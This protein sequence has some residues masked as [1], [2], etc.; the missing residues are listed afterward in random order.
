[1]DGSVDEQRP[2]A[3]DDAAD[4]LRVDLARR[5][6]PPAGRALDLAHDLVSLVVAE[7]YRGRQ[8]DLDPTLFAGNK[9]FELTLDFLDLGR[10]TAFRQDAKQVADELV[11]FCEERLEDR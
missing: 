9:A 6:H 8:L 3:E 2:G 1:A 11:G 5:L 10:A 7:F 4:Q